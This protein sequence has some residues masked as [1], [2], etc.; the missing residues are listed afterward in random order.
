MSATED[1][2]GSTNAPPDRPTVPHL[3]RINDWLLGGDQNWPIDRAEGQRL[4]TMMPEVDTLVL[5]SR[6]ATQRAVAHA[7]AAGVTQFVDLASGLPTQGCVHE[8][9]D[10]VRPARDTHVLYVDVD[11]VVTAHAAWLLAERADP[12]RHRVLTGDAL[13]PDALWPRIAA[14]GLIDP[15]APLCLLLTALLHFVKDA[16]QPAEHLAR[17]RDR[18]A[19]GSLLV[20]SQ[21][22]D[23]GTDPSRLMA[24]AVEFHRAEQPGQLRS[25]AEVA[26]LFGDFELL[27]PGLTFGPLWRPDPHVP[28]SFAD[29]PAASQLLIGVGRKPAAAGATRG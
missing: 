24:K 9:A 5:E 13:N 7:A 2:H 22:T 25:R 18:L 19:P 23:E 20:L 6:L 11:P 17:H 4:R 28:S 3:A 27:E 10:R 14:D 8:I 26:A 15:T 12:A 29:R 1:V 16:Q 21:S